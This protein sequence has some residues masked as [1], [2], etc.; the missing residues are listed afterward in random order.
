M[1]HAGSPSRAHVSFVVGTTPLTCT[2]RRWDGIVA[3]QVGHRP[4]PE[5]EATI[6]TQDEIRRAVDALETDVF[7]VSAPVT[8]ESAD[9]LRAVHARG[10]SRGRCILVLTTFGGH[11][12]A[13]YIMARDLR[14]AYPNGGFTVCIFGF[15]KSAGTLL[16]LGA[17]EIVMGSRGELGPLDVQVSEKDELGRYGSGLEIF[18]SLNVLTGASY[19]MFHRYLRE[20]VERND[21]QISTKTAAEI[22]TK[23]TVGLMSPISEQI[24]P[25]RLGRRQRAL[26]IAKRYAMQLGVPERA[27][28]TLTTDYP[29]HGFV[30]DLPEASKLL[31]PQKVRPPNEAERRLEAALATKP[32]LYFPQPTAGTIEVLSQPPRTQQTQHIPSETRAEASANEQDGA[33]DPG[34][35]AGQRTEDVVE[36]HQA[37]ST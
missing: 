24:D 13:A 20:T 36:A 28:V 31:G 3:T 10:A 1:L 32:D 6:S 12:D 33:G 26:D 37:N 35:M 17:H 9:S 14:N 19:T 15:C 8:R 5:R 34:E 21:G 18:S 23:L 29:D 2:A 7:Y 27:A 4:S 25:L 30:I 11:P 22:A 16:A